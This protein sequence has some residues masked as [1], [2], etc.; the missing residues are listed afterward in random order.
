M[1]YVDERIAEIEGQPPA[2]APF[3]NIVKQISRHGKVVYYYRARK[4]QRVRL[5]NR[6]SVTE[7]EFRRAYQ[8]AVLGRKIFT[9]PN[10][11]PTIKEPKMDIG[12]PGYIYFAKSGGALKIGFTR[13]LKGRMQTIQTSCADPVELLMVM[14]G[15]EGTEKFFHD[16]FADN[17]LGGE[18]FSL[19]GTLAELVGYKPR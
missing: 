10:H 2:H 6:D 11:R 15:T 12:K 17:R 1:A 4:G 13:S 9:R 18:W 7:T 19:T 3:K 5:P 14:P 8:E 16:R